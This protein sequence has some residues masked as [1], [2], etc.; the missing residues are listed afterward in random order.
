MYSVKND[1]HLLFE[2]EQMAVILI[3]LLTMQCLKY[4]PTT[5]LFCRDERT[6]GAKVIRLPTYIQKSDRDLCLSVCCSRAV[7]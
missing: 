2:L 4:F 6:R 1:V 7:E 5:P 3:F